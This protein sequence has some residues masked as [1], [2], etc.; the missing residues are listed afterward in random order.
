MASTVEQ[1]RDRVRSTGAR[2]TGARV[3]VLAALLEAG[4]ALANTDL[5][6]RLEQ[7]DS[8]ELLD[9]VTLYRVL[10]WLVETGL[11]HRVSGTDRTWRY[12]AQTLEQAGPVRHGHFRC[13]DC[14]RVICLEAPTGFDRILTDML[15][16]GFT[17]D[18]FEL[19]MLGR[20]AACASGAK[21]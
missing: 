14:A 12:S 3:R 5:Q 13:R 8:P 11:A 15:P 20:C 4:E 6:K 1:A 7:A 16:D 21:N 17:S 18:A 9:R 19:T 10:D 2:V